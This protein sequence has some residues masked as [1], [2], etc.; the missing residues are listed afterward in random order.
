MVIDCVSEQFD[1]KSM[2]KITDCHASLNP[3]EEHKH[4]D[5]YFARCKLPA[6]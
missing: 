5:T 4:T 2:K 1:M 3:A 6:N